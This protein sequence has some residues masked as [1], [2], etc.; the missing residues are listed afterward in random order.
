MKPAQ[1]A[2]KLTCP[3]NYYWCQARETLACVETARRHVTAAAGPKRGNVAGAK[4]GK[5]RIM[6]IMKVMIA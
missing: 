1:N 3:R 6:K 5:I 2:G 4:R